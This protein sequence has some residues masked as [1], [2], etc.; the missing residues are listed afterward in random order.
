MPTPAVEVL[1]GRPRRP[2]PADHVEL[3]LRARRADELGRQLAEAREEI[4]RLRAELAAELERSRSADGGSL[5]AENA[6]LRAR[7][8]DLEETNKRL[9]DRIDELERAGK[10]QAAPF[11]KGPPKMKPKAPGRKAGDD[12]GTR[13]SR[14]APERVD[15]T[16]EVPLPR[17]CECGGSIEEVSVAE[18]FQ[19]DLPPVRPFVRKFCV[20]VGRCRRCGRRVQPRHPLQTSDALGSAA[21][22]IGPNAFALATLLQKGS[23]VSW[24]KVSAFFEGAFS[25][26]VAPS[27][28]CRASLR[29]ARRLD[30]TYQALVRVVRQSPIVYADETGWRTGGHKRW[31]WGFTT[32]RVT[33][34]VIA[35]S[36]GGD[37][38]IEI[39]GAE[40]A[41]TLVRDGWSAYVAA[42]EHA[43]FQTCFFHLLRRARDILEVAKRGQAK[44]AHAVLRLLKA[45]LELRDR[46]GEL[47]E[48]GFAVLR[49][50]IEAQADRLLGRD[51]AYGPNAKF[52]KHLERERAHLFTFLRDPRVEPTNWPG[53]HAMRAGVLARKVSGGTRTDRGSAAHS[54]LTSVLTTARQQK[55]DP[56]D[57]LGVAFRARAP[58]ELDL[59][60]VPED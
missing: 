32:L 14:P 29:V 13:A 26:V 22:Q 1:P 51:P 58:V 55:R 53:E 6:R 28:L 46:R 8:T 56:L 19:T 59:L 5:E 40:F 50:K 57:L 30:P 60:P 36:R 17:T 37:V 52:L 41:A 24:R 16:V 27:A 31:L 7:V 11:S 18:Q 4:A 38:V 3:V 48:H 21:V 33:V 42:L 54:I 47:T 25:L 45:A 15:E 49:G 12:Y 10:R 20:H 2:T 44:F 39:L 35:P 9:L 43:I 34:F 23:A